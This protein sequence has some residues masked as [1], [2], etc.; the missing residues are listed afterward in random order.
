MIPEEETT[1][2]QEY[3]KR[4]FSQNSPYNPDLGDIFIVS[5]MK[6]WGYGTRLTSKPFRVGSVGRI[7]AVYYYCDCRTLD[8]HLT[9]ADATFM[10]NSCPAAA[11]VSEANIS[12]VLAEADINIFFAQMFQDIPHYTDLLRLRAYP[13]S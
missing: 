9:Y 3:L 12:P 8:S 10:L 5:D 13:T 4:L 1:P 7:E 6:T 2:H 11:R